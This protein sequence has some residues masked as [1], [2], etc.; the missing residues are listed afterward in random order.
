[1]RLHLGGHLSWYDPMKRDWL[2]IDLS[3]ARTLYDV[4]HGLAIPKD[5]VAVVAI[6]GKAARPEDASLENGDVVELYPPL[7]GG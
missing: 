3:E 2:D 1:M 7:G 6:N 5:E 4:L